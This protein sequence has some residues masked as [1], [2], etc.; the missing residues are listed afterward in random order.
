MAEKQMSTIQL[1]TNDG[2]MTAVTPLLDYQQMIPTKN[3][4]YVTEDK[5]HA[6]S[7]GVGKYV[8]DADTIR[9]LDY[10]NIHAFKTQLQTTKYYPLTVLCDSQ[11]YMYSV[12]PDGTFATE[13][14]VR[15]SIENIISVDGEVNLSGYATIKYV[16]DAI[17]NALKDY[18][19]GAGSESVETLTLFVYCSSENVVPDKP[20]GGSWDK[21]DEGNIV[22]NYPDGWSSL[23]NVDSNYPIYMSSSLQMIGGKIISDWSDPILISGVPG[24]PGKDGNSIEFKYT[25]TKNN[26]A[27]NNPNIEP[28]IWTDDPTGI[29]MEYQFEWISYRKTG[30]SGTMWSDAALWSKWGVD[31]KDGKDI[32]YIYYRNNGEVVTN[33]TPTDNI[34]ENEDYQTDGFYPEPW[35][36]DPQGVNKEHTHEWVCSRKKINGFWGSF[37]D[38]ASWAIKG[39][40]GQQGDNGYSIK[41]LYRA[42]DHTISGEELSSQVDNFRNNDDFSLAVSNGWNTIMPTNYDSTDWVWSISAYVDIDNKIIKVKDV[43]GNEIGWQGP[44]LVTGKGKDATPLNY[45]IYVYANLTDRPNKP[46]VTNDTNITYPI[47]NVW[48][49]YPDS[50]SSDIE[51]WW[52]CIGV[53][54][55]ATN[56]IT[57][58]NVIP[59]NGKDG[60]AKDG[61]MY[62]TRMSIATISNDSLSWPEFNATNRIPGNEWFLANKFSPETLSDDTCIVQTIALIDYSNSVDGSLIDTWCTP[63]RIS[64]ER[65]QQGPQGETGPT[66]GQ[67][68]IGLSGTPGIDFVIKY[69]RGTIK[70]TNND[71]VEDNV[72]DV[73][74]VNDFD[75]SGWVDDVNDIY[76]NIDA[77]FPYIYCVQGRKTYSRKGNTNEFDE[78]INWGTPFRLSG[79][80]GL[81]GLDGSTGK[82]GQIIYPAGVYNIDKE[83]VLD[84]MK[85]PYVFDSQDGHY[86]VL[87]V[88]TWCGKDQSNKLPSTSNGAW[89]K[90]EQFEAIYADIGMFRSALV[91]AAV[92]NGDYMF[93]QQGIDNNGNLSSAY[94][95]FNGS[96]DNPYASDATFKPA[97]CVNL[98]T[99]QQWNS[100]GK[101]MFKPDG[102][103]ELANGKIKFNADGSGELANGKITWDSNG[104]VIGN[105]VTITKDVS[106]N[107]NLTV[108]DFSVS[109]FSVPINASERDT[110]KS[111]VYAS[112]GSWG[113]VNYYDDT[114]IYS[115]RAIT[116]DTAD[117][118]LYIDLSSYSNNTNAQPVLEGCIVGKPNRVVKFANYDQTTARLD[119]FGVLQYIAI[120]H[121]EYAFDRDEGWSVKLLNQPIIITDS[122]ITVNNYTINIKI[123]DNDGSEYPLTAKIINIAVY[124]SNLN[125]LFQKSYNDID[126][127]SNYTISFMNTEIPHSIDFVYTDNNDNSYKLSTDSDNNNWDAT[128]INGVPLNINVIFDKTEAE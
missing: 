87:N 84:D 102:S 1:Y 2:N 72:L 5:G 105:G 24:E 18:D 93:S 42:V 112:N 92:F 47:D 7:Y 117:N 39:P 116:S 43:N 48:Y 114:S 104:L 11:G 28:D 67:G 62:E 66:G 9:T 64:G 31:G 77:S 76:N 95:N 8:V 126:G 96:T 88:N 6:V 53:V 59:L 21:D 82:N 113:Y 40:Q 79:T 75:S 74:D 34:Y 124:D 89:I 35:T 109:D 51:S 22:I 36:T 60:V 55:G 10:N 25:L 103:G 71:G 63:Y 85:A 49:D 50:D 19:G 37:S 107:A 16:D 44:I 99:G 57:W 122:G 68:P 61:K 100:G 12:I 14:Y 65:G 128:N 17:A 118:E 120:P 3:K 23:S 26:D 80:N 58:G 20:V 32:E 101:V 90:F 111:F 125:M 78:Q 13:D 45:N 27:P 94:E 119:S 69:C 123:N 98:K 106:I 15:T 110:N 115:I 73:S 41:T 56:N 81:D 97:Y 52:Q 33:P 86:Y 29:S 38:P 54:S 108:G 83:Y 121:E 91:G 4:Q 46:T 127:V 70:D 30:D